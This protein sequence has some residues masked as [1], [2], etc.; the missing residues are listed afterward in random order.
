VEMT[1]RTFRF[2]TCDGAGAL[3]HFLY[4]MENIFLVWERHFDVNLRELRLAIGA[5]VF[6]AK[7]FHD[8]EVA[9][10]SRDHQN[11]L[12]DLR[13]LRQ[14]VKL[15]VMNAAGNEIVARAF[16]RRTG[17]HR[18]LDLEE[19]K[20]VHRLADIENHAM[21]QFEILMRARTPQIE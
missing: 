7:A 15:A 11:L 16:R 10:H 6:V 13:R 19:T 1:E 12:E 3:H 18:R 14:R 4:H 5:Q 20:L 2:D 21:A 17:E 8:L 9:I